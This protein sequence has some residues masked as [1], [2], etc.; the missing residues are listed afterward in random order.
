MVGRWMFDGDDLIN[1]G[2]PEPGELFE[3]KMQFFIPEQQPEPVL[4]DMRDLNRQSDVA[5]HVEPPQCELGRRLG[6]R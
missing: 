1:R 6:H 5:R 3:G 2:L 4:G